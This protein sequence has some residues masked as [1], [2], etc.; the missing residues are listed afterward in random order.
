MEQDSSGTLPKQKRAAPATQNEIETSIEK[1]YL[2]PMTLDELLDEDIPEQVW[3]V[4][5]LVPHNSFT[6]VSGQPSSYKTWFA[7]YMAICLATHQPMFGRFNTCQ[8]GVLIV[9]EES[10]RHLLHRQL[11]KL[12]ATKGLPILLRSYHDF[13][14]TADN[15]ALLLLDCMAHDIKTVVFDS[16]SVIHDGNENEATDMAPRLKHL[17]KLTSKGIAVIVIAHN[18]KQGQF[19]GSGGS[20]IRG[21]SAIFA[22]ADA[23]ISL[24]PKGD[25]KLLVKPNKLRYAYLPKPFEVQVSGD[26]DSFRFDYIGE[27]GTKDSKEDIIKNAIL[28]LLTEHDKL[29]VKEITEKLKLAGYKANNHNVPVVIQLMVSEGTIVRVSGSTGNS[30]YYALNS[31][32]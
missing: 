21:S 9:D 6:I 25:G 31:N 12:G 2:P 22:A 20:E 19:P 4:E 28:E 14:L 18:R 3:L 24:F 7:L 23:V 29:N 26:D 27:V 32:M 15:V 16:L 1:M 30:Q 11:T 10:G 13:M 8:S 17:Q 5:G